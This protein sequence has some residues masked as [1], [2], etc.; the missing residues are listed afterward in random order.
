[1]ALLRDHSEIEFLQVAVG[2]VA[3]ADDLTGN[4][5]PLWGRDDFLFFCLT[6]P[7]F[8]DH[9]LPEEFGWGVAKTESA[10]IL[11][12]YLKST[13]FF[14]LFVVKSLEFVYP[15]TQFFLLTDLSFFLPIAILTVSTNSITI[16]EVNLDHAQISSDGGSTRLE[17]V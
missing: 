9:F 10:P 14:I 7:Y 1:M 11:H 17:R 2:V 8:F 6:E 12:F 15:T 16:S 3:D 13:G 4:W 5:G